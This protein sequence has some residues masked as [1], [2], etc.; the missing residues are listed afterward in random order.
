[1]CIR[2]RYINKS[3]KNKTTPNNAKIVIRRGI[4]IFLNAKVGILLINRNEI[5]IKNLYFSS[6]SEYRISSTSVFSSLFISSY[7]FCKLSLFV[8]LK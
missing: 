3:P 8:A 1:M 5:K 6:A 2:D 7:M 4:I